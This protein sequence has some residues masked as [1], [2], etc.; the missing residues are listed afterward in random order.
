MNKIHLRAFAFG[1]LLSTCIFGS[2]YYLSGDHGAASKL[3]NKE[4][5]A[6]VEDKGYKVVEQKAY[7]ELE[8]KAKDAEATPTKEE[9]K[10]T[11]QTN[12]TK[13][14]AAKEE[15]QPAE[16]VKEYKLTIISGMQSSEIATL[17]KDAGIITDAFDFE[18]YLIKSGYHTKV[19][20]GEFV[21]K[22]D[23][24]YEQLAKIITKS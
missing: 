13:E 3:S 9:T 14:E 2:Y 16:A 22:S 7:E 10:E 1:L 8:A 21:V 24:T 5:I 20:L 12:T 17:L 23:M 18:Q 6:Q 19:Q 11:E 4:L 15:E